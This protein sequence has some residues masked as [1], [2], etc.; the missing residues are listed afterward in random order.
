MGAGHGHRLFF[1]GHSA[2][3]RA[4]AHLK[5]LALVG[6]MLVVVA[7]PRDWYAAYAVEAIVLLAVIALS[8][9]PV[10]YLAPRM[11]I[12][13]PFALFAVLV[14]FISHGPRIEVLGVTVS[15]PG[16]Y[17]AIALLIKG[18]IGVL[19]SLT[20]AATT[21][22]QDLLRG[23]QRLRMPDLIVQIMGFMIRYLDVV[24][25]ELTRMMT[26]L[27][28][29]GCDPR[30]PRHWPVL[31]RSLGALFIRSYERGERVHL[32]MLSRGYDGRLP[33][34]ENA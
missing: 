8:G 13:L 21:E 25:A 12:E 17:A 24:T 5:L 1:H 22:P 18:T 19:A 33:S 29:R 4:P 10:G 16:L 9:V 26:A 3:H 2:V 7:T 34:V 30:S 32:A 28:S 6:F 11:V 31:A 23:L 15:E 20:L 27:K 14:P